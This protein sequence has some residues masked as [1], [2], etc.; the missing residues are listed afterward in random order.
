MTTTPTMSSVNGIDFTLPVSPPLVVPPLSLL[1]LARELLDVQGLVEEARLVAEA[2]VSAQALTQAAADRLAGAPEEERVAAQRELED[3]TDAQTQAE[4]W[5]SAAFKRVEDLAHWEHG[6]QYLPELTQALALSTFAPDTAVAN[7]SGADPTT[8][9]LKPNA[10]TEAVTAPSF[11]WYDPFQVIALDDRSMFGFRHVDYED[12]RDRARRA[13]VAHESYDVE[14]EFWTG[15]TIPTNFH[16]TASPNTPTSSPHRTTT[17]WP[18][19]DP[20]PGTTL[21]VAVGLGLALEALDQAIADSEAGTGMI[22]ATPFM[23]QAFMR[24]FSYI[25]DPDGKVYTVN[26][27]LFV[28]GYGYKGTGPD[29][30]DR[31]T[32]GDGHLSVGVNTLSSASAAFTTSDIGRLVTGTGLAA[33]THILS[34]TDSTHVILD[35]VA[36]ANETTS[37]ITIHGLGGDATGSPQQWCYATEMQYWCRGD[38]HAYPRDFNEMSPAVPVDNNAPVRVERSWAILGNQILRAAVLVDS[39]VLT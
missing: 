10:S 8:L 17:A 26:H 4:A 12:R 13:L 19:P 18:N 9:N 21:G 14:Q 11:L 22:H 5:A 1:D 16:L 39:T 30:A 6:F 3:A 24:I 33:G 29:Q 20:A 36:L 31:T 34:V 32:A 7:T 23:V 28:P 25:R 27:N 2:A 37:A 38:L 35:K 15:A